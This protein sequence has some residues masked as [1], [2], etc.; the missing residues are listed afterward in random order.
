MEKFNLFEMLSLGYKIQ[1]G[2]EVSPEEKETYSRWEKS[3][4]DKMKDEYRRKWQADENNKQ[5]AID[6]QMSKY[7]P[8][9]NRACIGPKCAMFII[10]ERAPIAFEE[11]PRYRYYTAKCGYNKHPR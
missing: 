10:L 8:S 4:E 9:I 5:Y 7:C 1:Q 3:C 2:D 6:A 11:N